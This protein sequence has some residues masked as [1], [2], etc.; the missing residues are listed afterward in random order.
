MITNQEPMLVNMTIKRFS[1]TLFFKTKSI[2]LYLDN[3]IH[4]DEQTSIKQQ[5]KLF[6]DSFKVPVLF[7]S[8]LD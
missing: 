7:V 1:I 6:I 4:S 3:L 5:K 2:I 8:V